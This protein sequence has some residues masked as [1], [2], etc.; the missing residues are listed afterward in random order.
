MCWS[1]RKKLYLFIAKD[2]I[3]MHGIYKMTI[4]SLCA[5]YSPLFLGWHFSVAHGI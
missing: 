4:Y 1:Y 3:V 5:L 2:D